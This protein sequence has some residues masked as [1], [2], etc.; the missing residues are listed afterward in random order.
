MKH[1]FRH[2]LSDYLDGAVTAIERAEIEEHLKACEKCSDALAELQKTI[3]QVKQVEDVEP[4][5]WMTQKI[6]AKVREESKGKAGIW[7]E[8]LLPLRIRPAVGAL[9]VLFLAVTS[10]YIY[11]N[12]QPEM[13][14]AE[15]P[16]EEGLTRKNIS[17]PAAPA[18]K[19]KAPAPAHAQDKIGRIDDSSLRA[20]QVPQAEGYKSLDMKYEYEKPAA[21]APKEEAAAPA[22][23]AA[24]APAKAAG[25]I[26]EV[27]QPEAAERT[28]QRNNSSIELQESEQPATVDRRELSTVQEY[29]VPEQYVRLIMDEKKMLAATWTFP[30]T[31]VPPGE[32]Y[33]YGNGLLILDSVL[34]SKNKEKRYLH[35]AFS[36]DREFVTITFIDNRIQFDKN[37]KAE[38]QN[39]DRDPSYWPIAAIDVSK[40]EITYRVDS[41]HNYEEGITFLGLVFADWKKK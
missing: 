37:V 33:F 15:A 16:M 28:I 3:E 11:T 36:P 34:F 10:F 39:F 23:T 19:G 26:G 25:L 18:P 8:L 24:P 1:D 12:I 4:P 9:A 7:N 30:G 21:P 27:R 32:M 14:Y 6:M 22:A 29:P 38:K 31:D 35:Y 17:A 2:K 20:R 41:H 13:K 5:A 40:K